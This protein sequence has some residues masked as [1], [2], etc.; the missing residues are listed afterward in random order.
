MGRKK[1]E[2]PVGNRPWERRQREEKGV[3]SALFPPE[4]AAPPNS[5][6]KRGLTRLYS[7]SPPDP[8]WAH[9]SRAGP[10]PQPTRAVLSPPCPPLSWKGLR[11]RPGL[12]GTATAPSGSRRIAKIHF[13]RYKTRGRR[14]QPLPGASAQRKRAAAPLRYPPPDTTKSKIKK[15]Y[16]LKVVRKIK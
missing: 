7:P 15:I 2:T 12:D 16:I 10:L 14:T 9:G 5:S 13:S 8:S 3:C 4:G 1:G 11:Q 6:P